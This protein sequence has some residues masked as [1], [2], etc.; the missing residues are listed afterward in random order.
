[1]TALGD[2]ALP[3]AGW[4]VAPPR[5][6]ELPSAICAEHLCLLGAR[7]MQHA[8]NGRL[9]L[10]PPSDSSSDDASAEVLSCVV[11]WTPFEQRTAVDEAIIQA[12]S[13]LMA[14]HGRE[15]GIPRRLGLD[16]AS[17]AAGTIAAQGLLAGCLARA[18]GK[19][20][21]DVRSSVL[22]G[23]LS[24]LHHHLA[25]GTCG[26]SFPFQPMT[27][28]DGRG[29]P[30]HTADGAWIELEALSGDAWLNFWKAL[31]VDPEL[32]SQAWLPF[33]YRYLAG[34]CTL[35]AAL[36]DATRRRIF[37]DVKSAATAN[38]LAACRVRA[39]EEVFAD[40][41]HYPWTF[42]SGD[43][44][45]LGVPPAQGHAR[46]GPLSGLRVIEV[47]SRLQGPFAGQL[48]RQLGAEVVKVEPRGGDFGRCSPPFAGSS[49]AAYL[50][51]NH[52]K[53]VE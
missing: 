7:E 42:A 32:A 50:A 25:I 49:G 1:V 22:Q 13:G 45:H 16:V 21:R 26:G 29:P 31:D 51:Y 19:G 44:P 2:A 37:A 11:S 6:A 35:P 43:Q 39:Y 33:V 20:V 17:V 9:E 34:R 12:S 14:V 15:R 38:G 47:T 5:D 8:G 10:H 40:R 4:T 23:A 27:D 28:G 24:Y 46:G 41:P 53:R 18:R 3:F 52:G 48:L 30:F 36:H